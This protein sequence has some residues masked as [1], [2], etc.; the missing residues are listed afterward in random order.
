MNKAISCCLFVIVSGFCSCD[1]RT[2]QSD[3]LYF[4]HFDLFTLKG[5]DTIKKIEEKGGVEVRF[6]EGLLNYINFH[7]SKREIILNLED[8]F[9]VNGRQIYLYSSQNFHGGKAGQT[10]VYGTHHEEYKDLIYVSLNDT[11]ICKS[12]ELTNSTNYDYALYLYIN[13][14]DSITKYQS[15]MNTHIEM[16][17]SKQKLY[18]VW[19]EFLSDGLRKYDHPLIKIKS[20][21]QK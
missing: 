14:E 11:I 6:K 13:G 8:T 4:K 9:K 2:T 18:T 5:I 19:Q 20:L 17:L 1:S 3:T 15:G 7:Q 12:F 16:N 10:R 21:P